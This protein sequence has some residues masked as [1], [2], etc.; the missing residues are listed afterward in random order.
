QTVRSTSTGVFENWKGCTVNPEPKVPGT[1]VGDPPFHWELPF[2]LSFGYWSLCPATQTPWFEIG[3]IPVDSKE[4]LL[5][6]L[7]GFYWLCPGGRPTSPAPAAR[8]LIL[9]TVGLLLYAVLSCF[10]SGMNARDTLGMIWTLLVS[11][12]ACVLGYHLMAC[13]SREWVL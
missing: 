9:L 3:S 5:V 13:R 10:W 7:A 11:G 8:Y 1:G 2:W 4:W 6:G 12:A